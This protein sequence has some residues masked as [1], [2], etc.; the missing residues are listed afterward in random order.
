MDY[1]N[2]KHHLIEELE[3]VKKLDSDKTWTL[4]AKASSLKVELKAVQERI[5]LLEGSSV[6]STNREK[7]G[8]V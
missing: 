6:W 3:W 2:K 8:W 1:I 4:M 7:Y 5:Q